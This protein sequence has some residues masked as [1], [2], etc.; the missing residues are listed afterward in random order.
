MATARISL[1]V[2]AGTYFWN[3]APQYIPA[4]PPTP[5]SSPK[6]QSGPTAMPGVKR[7]EQLVEH[8]ACHRRDKGRHQRRTRGG[9][10]REAEERNEEGRHDR[11]PADA[12]N[13][14]DDPHDE[15]Q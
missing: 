3:I 10:D 9:I 14:S 8:H 11:T 12:V 5:N 2:L 13:P 6:N 4:I 7:S 1:M 15:T